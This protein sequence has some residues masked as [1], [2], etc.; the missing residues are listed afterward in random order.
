MAPRGDK[1]KG[2]GGGGEERGEGGGD[3]KN[4][5]DR[6]ATLEVVG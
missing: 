3:I 6:E 2:G 1:N 5:F 4:D